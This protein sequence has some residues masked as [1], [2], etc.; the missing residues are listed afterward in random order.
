[1]ANIFD[2]PSQLPPGELFETLVASKNVLIERIIST[3]QTTPPGE[4][5]N[6][7]RAEWVMVLQGEAEL[8]Y[9]DGSRIKLQAGDYVFIPAHQ[10]HR[11]EYTSSNP[12]C[13]WLA[14]HGQMS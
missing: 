2:L 7:E 8:S 11:V 4:W 6:Q 14:I 9:L 12:P 13:I 10:K 3:G 1:M 5:Y